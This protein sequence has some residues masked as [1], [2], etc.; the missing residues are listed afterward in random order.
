MG[1]RVESANPSGHWLWILTLR[2][3]YFYPVVVAGSLFGTWGFA[4]IQLGR[5][6]LPYIEFPDGILLEVFFN[7]AAILH[8]ASPFVIPFSLGV[9]IQFP[10]GAAR[11]DPVKVI[12]RIASVTCLCVMLIGFVKLYE[13]DPYSAVSWFFD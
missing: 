2:F 3:L 8:V 7:I 1:Y 6:P 11:I 13:L 9:A 10:F 12:H 4:A 5:P